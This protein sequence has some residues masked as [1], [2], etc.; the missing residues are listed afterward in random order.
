MIINQQRAVSVNL[1]ALRAY[2]RRIKATLGLANKAWNVCLVDDR[3]IQHLNA[4]YR[5]QDRPT[6]VLAFAWQS[7]DEIGVGEHPGDQEFKN[8]LGDVVISS[9]TALRQAR[10][11]GHAV[12]QEINWLMLHGTLHLLGYD[13]ETDDGEMTSLELKLRRQLDRRPRSLLRGA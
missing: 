5:G 8:F 11:E 9:E 7:D 3:Q 12:Q 10:R 2:L 6:D 4:T 1:S 13:H